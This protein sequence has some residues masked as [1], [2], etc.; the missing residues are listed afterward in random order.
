MIFENENDVV[1]NKKVEK[2]TN[3]NSGININLSNNQISF[4]VKDSDVCYFYYF[5]NIVDNLIKFVIN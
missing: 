4:D 1:V 2:N 5:D 3:T